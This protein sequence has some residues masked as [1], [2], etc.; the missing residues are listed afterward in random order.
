MSR[1]L[2]NNQSLISNIGLDFLT[3][4]WC[5]DNNKPK[6]LELIDKLRKMIPDIAITSDVMVGFPG[7]SDEDFE[8]TMDLVRRVEFDSLFSFKY[9]DRKGTVA[10]KMDGKIDKTV[11]SS[12]LNILQDLQKK[13]TLKK[14]KALEGIQLEVLVEGPSKRVGQLTGRTASHKVVNFNSDN[15]RIGRLC[16]VTIKHSFLNS[17]RG[18]VVE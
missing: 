4:K 13:I 18:E 3:D 9:S 7:E 1:R 16:T 8:L 17:L 12:R 11:K 14:N 6:P 5:D 2:L 10:E 15:S